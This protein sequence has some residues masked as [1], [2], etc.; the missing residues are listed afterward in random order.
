MFRKLLQPIQNSQ[1]IGLITAIFII[2]VVGMFGLLLSRYVTTHSVSSAED[3]LWGQA[4]YSAE[5]AIN[6]RLLQEDNSGLA[7]TNPSIS[8]QGFAIEQTP[9][10]TTP[11][12]KPTGTL[13]ALAS[14]G[15]VAREVEVH[16]TLT[17]P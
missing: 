3:Y 8:I 4:L 12:S 16:Y 14:Q 2:T 6:L 11:I 13:R 10:V 17:L 7:V 1:G 9:I 5:S 15:S